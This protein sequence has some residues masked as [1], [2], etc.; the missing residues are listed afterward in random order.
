MQ[1]SG[2][3]GRREWIRVAFGDT[4]ARIC[5][6]RCGFRGCRGPETA[7]LWRRRRFCSRPPPESGSNEFSQF[8]AH[9]RVLL[10]LYCGLL[11]VQL[12]LRLKNARALIKNALWEKNTDPI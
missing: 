6:C 2:E 9:I 1:G 8:L 3:E 5:G 7:A 12:A 4:I 11:S 10:P